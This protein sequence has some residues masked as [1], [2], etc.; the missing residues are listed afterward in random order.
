MNE[1]LLKYLLDKNLLTQEQID[2]LQKEHKESGRS[3]RELIAE[4][5]L[6]S[7]E[8]LMEALAAVF[9]LPTVKLYEQQIPVEVRQLVKPDLMRTNFVLPFAFDANDP[10]IIYVAMNDPMNMRGRE[11]I[12]MATK[13]RV[14]PYLATASDILVTI[15]RYFGSDEMMEAAELYTRG[16]ELDVAEEDAIIR[17][18]INSSPVVVLVNSLVEQA[19]RQRASDIHIEAGPDMVRVRYRVDGVLYTTAK[20]NLRLLPAII[21]RIKII[22]GMDIS[23]KRKP[24]DGRFSLNVDR[25]EYDI[26]VSTL[27]TVHGEK[28]VMRLNQKKALHR[29]KETL[30]LSPD[31]MV[32]F[33][34]IM[35]HPNGIVLV[36]G[37]T[38]SGKSTTLYTVLSELNNDMVNIV[39]VED[40]VESNIEGINQVQVNVKADM[41]FANAL[42]SILRQDPDIIMIGEIRDSETASIAVQASITGHLVASTLHTNDSASSVTRLLDMG[43]ESYL[44]ADSV[45]G[46]IAQRLVRRL[47]PNCKKERELQPYEADYLNLSEEE[48]KT[49][50]VYDAVGCQRCNGKGYY[51]R[52]GVYEILE[53]TPNIRNLIAARASTN[54]L[55]DAAIEEGMLTLK[56][57]VRRLVLNGTTTL[58]EMHAISTEDFDFVNNLSH[59]GEDLI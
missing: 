33:D 2:R 13:C 17:E 6:I 54:T 44:I 12:T 24:Q 39:T 1:K 37:P 16:N 14:R 5:G 58:S 4:Q 28:C 23:E 15:D 41:T 31:D 40:P 20:Y 53:V 7:E 25:K 8:Q 22:S 19:V 59:T 49:Q 38:G 48:R 46:I 34:R 42:R 18:D 32:K 43:V 29:S 11:L 3:V 57:A 21:A 10:G 35:D 55:R 50:K 36:T 45:V 27:P 51:G 56:Q 9:R 52:I 47:C 26:R 30:G